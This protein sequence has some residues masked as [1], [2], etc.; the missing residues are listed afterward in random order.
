MAIEEED[1]HE[2][3]VSE[4]IDKSLDTSSYEIISYGA[5]YTLSVLYEKL[6]KEEIIT[7]EFQRKYVWKIKQAS[8]LIESFLLGLPIPGIFLAVDKPT[9]NLL[10][11]DGQQRL[12]TIQAFRDG[13]F[14]LNDEDFYLV[15]VNN[16]WIGKK[17]VD[18]DSIDRKRFDDSV[19]RATIIKQIDPQ[20]NT[21]VYHIFERLNTGGTSLQNQEVRNCVYF[22][23]FNSLLHELNQDKIWRALYNMPSPNK[24]MKDEELILRFL[25]L[26][27]NLDSYTKPMNEF[28]SK[29]MAIKRN[30]SEEELTSIKK[31][32]SDTVNFIYQKIGLTAFRPKRNI[33][34]AAFD[35]VMY[36]IAKYKD[37]L[38]EDLRDSVLNLFSDKA[39]L[40][41]IS[42]G[43]TDEDV[44]KM[45]MVIAKNYL[46]KNEK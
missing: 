41:A 18:L 23:K 20:D 44:I 4:E 15:D 40:K 22:G 29:F 30:I 8:K 28:L 6:K 13:K 39:Y 2:I 46:V 10:V 1:E 24:R 45:R 17:Y 11:V 31:V 33:N 3:I 9:G 42:E 25:A 35:S 21:S 34:I 14:P 26:Y 38:K 36:T 32:F 27:Y 7:P 12:K 37:N 16:K 5:D 43:T 19:L